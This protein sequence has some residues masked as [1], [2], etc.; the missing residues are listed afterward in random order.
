MLP[1]WQ[2]NKYCNNYEVCALLKINPDRG[3]S[4]LTDK[5]T[6]GAR[7]NLVMKLKKSD[8]PLVRIGLITEKNVHVNLETFFNVFNCPY[9]GNVCKVMTKISW[10]K[11]G[12]TQGSD[13]CIKKNN[14]QLCE[15]LN[16][17]CTDPFLKYD[18]KS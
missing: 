13:N 3:D 5:K 16:R 8:G 15:T 7:D 17:T 6:K 12:G 14:P 9:F 2:E 10:V 18:N 11:L 4:S 1:L